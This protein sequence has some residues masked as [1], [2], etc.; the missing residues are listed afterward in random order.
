MISNLS[1]RSTATCSRVG[2]TSRSTVQMRSVRMPVRMVG[3]GRFHL[4]RFFAGQQW[5][6]REE[7]TFL[8]LP[9]E[10]FTC[11]HVQQGID[12]KLTHTTRFDRIAYK[13]S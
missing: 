7:F 13:A 1:T 12:T 11:V 10:L 8:K 9:T 2:F 3:V 6:Y 4:L 5:Y